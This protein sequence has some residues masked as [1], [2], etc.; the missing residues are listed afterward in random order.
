MKLTFQRE[1]PPKN[2]FPLTDSRNL[3]MKNLDYH[4]QFQAI[5]NSLQHKKK[6]EQG[7]H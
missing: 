7:L 2:G 4:T 3:I 6:S 5:I 1:P